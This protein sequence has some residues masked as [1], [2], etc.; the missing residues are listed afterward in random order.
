[1]KMMLC[2][3]ISGTCTAIIDGILV[4]LIY[5]LKSSEFMKK[6]FH[7][8]QSPVI[9]DAAN[10]AD[11]VADKTFD[12]VGMFRDGL[13][14]IRPQPFLTKYVALDVIVFIVFTLVIYMTF[15]MVFSHNIIEYFKD[16]NRGVERIRE[17]DLDTNIPVKG[18]D[19]ISDLAY[20]INNMR[21]ELKQ[22]IAKER[23]LE[24]TKNELITN[25]AHDLRTP[26]TSMT[27]YLELIKGN[28]DID[29][30]T[31]EKYINIAYD[32]SKRLERL[33][34]DLFDYT[35]FEKNKLQLS[36]VKLNITKFVEQLAEEFYPSIEEKRLELITSFPKTNLYIRG[37][38]EL[39]ARALGNL[40]SNAIKYGAD[41]KQI[42]MELLEDREHNHVIFRVTNYGRLIPQKDI[43]KIFEQF[44]RVDASR[45]STGT[46][47]GLA[48]AKNIIEMHKGRIEA[49]SDEE[50]TVF[51]VFFNMND[52]YE[53]GVQL[54]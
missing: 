34:T 38:G 54:K 18:Y 21:V 22:S 28:R 10:V 29:D 23:E 25:V 36:L 6:I 27:G 35:R 41:G 4:L 2:A 16:I 9:K 52:N 5:F 47:L 32:K 26:L 49:K 33:V 1:M 37:D 11:N 15:Y 40:L 31:R 17:G 39:L 14:M 50:G 45:T 43:G 46:G 30:E 19:E 13:I 44:Y 42:R 24:K 48:I 12:A 7:I 51:E 3:A 20:S 53:L 8:T